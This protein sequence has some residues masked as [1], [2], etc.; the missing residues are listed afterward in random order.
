M[1]TS[2]VALI[3][4]AAVVVRPHTAMG[5]AKA[6]GDA[7]V[8]ADLLDSDLSVAEALAK[9]NANRLPVGQAIARYGQQ[10]GDSLPL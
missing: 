2:N 10:L 9:Y 5:A 7:M 4:D 1:S 3:G 6:A 8:L